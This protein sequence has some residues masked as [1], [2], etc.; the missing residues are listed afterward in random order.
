VLNYIAPGVLRMCLRPKRINAN[1][2]DGIPQIAV[3]LYNESV[4]TNFFPLLE[5]LGSYSIQGMSYISL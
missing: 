4:I 1:K 3:L 5:R 2:I